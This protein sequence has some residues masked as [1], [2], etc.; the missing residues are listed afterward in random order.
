[1]LSMLETKARYTFETQREAREKVR[2]TES[3]VGRSRSTRYIE[4]PPAA[5]FSANLELARQLVAPPRRDYRIAR[6]VYAFPFFL[7]RANIKINK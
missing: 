1:M 7:S 6:L 4:Q 3:A 5:N 2:D